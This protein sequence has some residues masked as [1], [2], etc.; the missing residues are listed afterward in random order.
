M[1]SHHCASPASLDMRGSLTTT[2][3]RRLIRTPP[4]A[5]NVKEKIMKRILVAAL[6]GILLVG[7]ATPAL[8][9]TVDAP[10]SGVVIAEDTRGQLS[11][12]PTAPGAITVSASPRTT[13]SVFPKQGTRAKTFSPRK[14]VT[15][16]RGIVT[17]TGLRNGVA[18]TVLTTTASTT[19]TP[20]AA[21]SDASALRVTTTGSNSSVRLTW[22]HR[23]SR[24]QGAV[25][26]LVEAI[27][28]AGASRIVDEV[29]SRSATLKGLDPN[30][31]YTLRV[32]PVN[33]LG[34]GRATSARM[35]RSLGEIAGLVAQT[36]QAPVAQP[37]SLTPVT[38][39]EPT[40]KPQPN[41]APAPASEPA[42]AAAPAPAP[43]PAAPAAPPA[44]RTRTVYV[45]PDGF[46]EAGDLCTQT[47]AYTYRT[48]TATQPYTYRSESRVEQCAGGDCPGSEYRNFG[49]DWSGTTCPNGGTMH[50]GQ[51]MGWSG[52]SK[53]VTYQVKN[54]APS[55]WYDNGS[56]YAKDSQVK[57]AMPAGF[58]DN[59]SAWVKTAAKVAREVPA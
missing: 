13:V 36:P 42:P 56:D 45:C 37:P 26:F 21:T 47:R 22:A 18:Y 6:T 9:S 14:G 40:V 53:T 16:S 54:A 23:E 27:P 49:T 10:S 46:S 44:P 7:V 11:A 50:G 4:L 29:S 41:P 20:L 43:A 17:F 30:V 32:T 39:P 57:D 1:L 3:H 8:A 19:V 59:G 51:C 34:E 15:N 48:E 24:Q 55:G 38:A 28:G 33:A 12:T 2:F 35:N 52:S 31:R 25:R 58:T 5:R